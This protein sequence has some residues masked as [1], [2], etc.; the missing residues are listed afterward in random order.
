MHTALEEGKKG[1]CCA[2]SDRFMHAFSTDKLCFGHVSVTLLPYYTFVENILVEGKA[3][4]KH[5]PV[6]EN[7]KCVSSHLISEPGPPLHRFKTM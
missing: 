1:N 6:N 5:R 2:M 3:R 7:P 4:N